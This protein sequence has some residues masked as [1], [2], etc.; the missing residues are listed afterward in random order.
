MR[1]LALLVLSATLSIPLAATPAAAGHACVPF[2]AAELDEVIATGL[3]V[4]VVEGAL[5]A[6][7]LARLRE[8]IDIEGE[9]DRLVIVFIGPGVR[10]GVITGEQR[11]QTING[12]SDLTRAILNAARGAAADGSRG[13]HDAQA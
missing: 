1:R 10:I 11:C 7:T 5:L 4:E 3:P 13:H 9:P 2:S 8:H 6:P 12:P